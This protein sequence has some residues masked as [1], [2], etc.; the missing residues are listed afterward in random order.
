MFFIRL[1]LLSSLIPEIKS[2][3]CFCD[4][5]IPLP[6]LV[7]FSSALAANWLVVTKLVVASRS[8]S[9]SFLVILT[10]SVSLNLWQMIEILLTIEAYHLPRRCSWGKFV[11]GNAT[12][13]NASILLK[14]NKKVFIPPYKK[15][16][17]HVQTQKG[18]LIINSNSLNEFKACLS[19]NWI[20]A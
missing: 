6:S 12:L 15:N 20:C 17:L 10:P 18:L 14:M 3:I 2:A 8:K 5:P 19:E 9:P 13:S 1:I 11:R 7:M 16:N 4:G